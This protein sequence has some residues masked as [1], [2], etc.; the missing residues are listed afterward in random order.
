ME[1]AIRKYSKIPVHTVLELACGNSPHMVELATRGYE[2]CGLDLNPT[3]IEF[4]QNKAS[5][6]NL[7]VRFY[8]ANFIDF[9]LEGPK[10]FIYIML[11]SLY[12]N[13][14]DELVSHFSNVYKALKPGGLYFLDW[15]IDF[16]P[17]DNSEDSWVM[18]RDG[19]TVST[20]YTTRLRNA[21]EQLYEENIL[22]TIRDRGRQ[23]KLLHTGIRRAIFPQEFVLAATKLNDFELLGWWNDWNWNRP[24]GEGRGEIIRPI[25]I[26]RKI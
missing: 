13:N 15:C 20:R 4:A 21:A 8:L 5:A 2:Y 17:L 3:M 25:T 22:F 9:R 19:I 18:R 10:D 12:V 26:L 16:S 23:Q 11:G 6:H 7:D 14:A 1:E 24:L